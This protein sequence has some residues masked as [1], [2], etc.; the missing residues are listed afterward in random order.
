[1]ATLPLSVSASSLPTSSSFASIF[2]STRLT[3]NDATEATRDGS[4]ARATPRR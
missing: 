4:A 2:E 3:K 1:M